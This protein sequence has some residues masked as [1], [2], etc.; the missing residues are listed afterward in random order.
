MVESTSRAASLAESNDKYEEFLKGLSL[1]SVGLKQSS[2]SLNR[3]GLYEIWDAKKAPLRDFNETYKITK[4]GTNF[5]ESSGLFVATVRESRTASP[6]VA[7][8]CEFEAHLHGTE[9]IQKILVQRFV[10]SA[11]QLILIPYA[12]QFVSSVTAQ[13]SIPPLV[14]PLSIGSRKKLESG[15]KKTKEGRAK[16]PVTT[17]TSRF[18]KAKP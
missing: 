18:P 5:F 16:A 4:M 12:R 11:F 7:V 10:D 14:I 2:A 1:I 13:M 3:S 15:A 6:V 8:E 17:S 9:P